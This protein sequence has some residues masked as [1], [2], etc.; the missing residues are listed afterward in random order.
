MATR[1]RGPSDTHLPDPTQLPIVDVGHQT[2]DME[3][4]HSLENPPIFADKRVAAWIHMQGP[5]RLSG[6]DPKC[7]NPT[8]RGILNQ[9]G[10]FVN[11]DTGEGWPS[12]QTLAR[13]MDTTVGVVNR[14]LK[15][16]EELGYFTITKRLWPGSNWRHNV[17]HFAGLDSAWLVTE[18]K[19]YDSAI[20]SADKAKIAELERQLSILM[21]DYAAKGLDLPQGVEME[22]PDNC[23]ERESAT[24]E[25]DS[26]SYYLS[27]SEVVNQ[28]EAESLSLEE[29]SVAL[30]ESD[31]APPSDPVA[32]FVDANLESLLQGGWNHRGGILKVFRE[33][34]A[35]MDRWRRILEEEESEAQ[36]LAAEE[37]DDRELDTLTG[38]H[39]P[40]AQKLMVEVLAKLQLQVP[41]PMFETWLKQLSGHDLTGDTLTIAAPTPLAINWL[42]RRQYHAIATIVSELRGRETEVTFALAKPVAESEPSDST[43]AIEEPGSVSASVAINGFKVN[44][45]DGLGLSHPESE[46]S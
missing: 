16:A 22:V 18:E 41:K 23:T 34:P 33:D 8:W 40:E 44:Q 31:T 11:P 20:L 46:A 28:W 19:G 14:V 43:Q 45:N 29:I 42:Y 37:P 24:K 36:E 25:R 27:E 10:E 15:G 26:D 21:A 32:E 35:E 13:L 5:R 30:A 9:L 1:K 2:S 38:S 3:M 12:Q 17:Y 6:Q 39:D 7:L 4:P